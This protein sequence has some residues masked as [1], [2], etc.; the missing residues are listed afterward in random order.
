LF[1]LPISHRVQLG[2]EL[3]TTRRYGYCKPFWAKAA[4]SAAPS[5]VR[6]VEPYNNST[7]HRYN[8][9]DLAAGLRLSSNAN[10]APD[11]Q[12]IERR[13]VVL[14]CSERE[15]VAYALGSRNGNA[16]LPARRQFPEIL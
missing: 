5:W 8:A 6:R 3:S 11:K 9:N 13:V 14:I 7:G 1:S 2:A 10:A 12:H 15:R 16:F 4:E